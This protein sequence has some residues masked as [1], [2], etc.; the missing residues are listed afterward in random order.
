MSECEPVYTQA[1]GQ[2]FKHF[3][4]LRINFASLTYC[5]HLNENCELWK[6][7]WKCIRHDV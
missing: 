7:K 4:V 2:P 5:S 6:W 1:T 3:N